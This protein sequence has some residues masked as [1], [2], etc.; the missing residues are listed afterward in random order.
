M[1]EDRKKITF[2]KLKLTFETAEFNY[3]VSQVLITAG[4]VNLDMYLSDPNTKPVA[5]EAGAGMVANNAYN[6]AMKK[7]TPNA[8]FLFAAIN[9]ACQPDAA[10][11]L[12]GVAMFDLNGAWHA[13]NLYF[14]RAEG[15]DNFVARWQVTLPTMS[16]LHL[17]TIRTLQV[18]I[19]S[20]HRR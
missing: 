20:G 6:A 19:V 14:N 13:I 8:K 2:P 17:P 18:L 15:G 3:W 11:I 7:Y 12:S 1:S 4:G 16:R 9:E 10:S 5:P